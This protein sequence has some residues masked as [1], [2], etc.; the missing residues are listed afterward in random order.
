MENVKNK[1]ISNPTI[2]GNYCSYN[3]GIVPSGFF[4]YIYIHTHIYIYTHT[5]THIYTHTHTYIHT[6]IHI[7]IYIYT[8]VCIYVFR[9]FSSYT[10]CRLISAQHHMLNSILCN[11]YSVTE[12]K[13]FVILYCTYIYS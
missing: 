3:F 6:Y 11:Y 2:L 10:T 7:H 12:F 1:I 9:K 13:C 8:P 4:L 5:H